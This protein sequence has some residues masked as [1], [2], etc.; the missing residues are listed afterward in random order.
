MS[1]KYVTHKDK[2]YLK[3]PIIFHIALLLIIYLPICGISKVI[4]FS[5]AKEVTFYQNVRNSLSECNFS[6]HCILSLMMLFA[7]LKVAFLDTK[8]YQECHSIELP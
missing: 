2:T 7:F 6:K 8:E 4:S 3:K 1:K 5:S